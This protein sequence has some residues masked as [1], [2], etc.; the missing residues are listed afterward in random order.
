MNTRDN[1]HVWK[2]LQVISEKEFQKERERLIKISRSIRSAF[3]SLPHFTDAAR[4]GVDL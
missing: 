3:S 2:I 4:V 1:E